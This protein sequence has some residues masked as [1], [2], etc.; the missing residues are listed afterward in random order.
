MNRLFLSPMNFWCTFQ[1]I[2]EARGKFS[3]VDALKQVRQIRCE[4]IRSPKQMRLWWRQRPVGGLFRHWSMIKRSLFQTKY[5][6]QSSSFE[7]PLLTQYLAWIKWPLSVYALNFLLIRVVIRI[8]TLTPISLSGNLKKTF[9]QIHISNCQMYHTTK[10]AMFENNSVKHWKIMQTNWMKVAKHWK[11]APLNWI[12][13]AKHEKIVR[14]HW[15]ITQTN[16]GIVRKHET[17]SQI[18][19]VHQRSFGSRK[20]GFGTFVI[21]VVMLSLCFYRHP[22]S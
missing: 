1:T 14:K 5:F 15:K 10:V 19:T 3:V 18:F 20:V 12:K 6:M 11:I 21:D 9:S 4:K 22:S 2:I 13:V 8:R 17:K 16:W 7:I